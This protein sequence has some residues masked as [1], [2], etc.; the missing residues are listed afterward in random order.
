MSYVPSVQLKNSNFRSPNTKRRSISIATNAPRENHPRN[1]ILFN[2]RDS[3]LELIAIGPIG[4]SEPSVCVCERV[5]VEGNGSATSFECS[6]FVWSPKW[7][8]CNSQHSNKI[9]FFLTSTPFYVLFEELLDTTRDHHTHFHV[10]PVSFLR[11]RI[12]HVI[13]CLTPFSLEPGDKK[14]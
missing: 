4:L 3:H 14:S 12:S 5:C 2:S 6:C 9:P 11:D 1:P 10:I 13:F 7:F 8:S